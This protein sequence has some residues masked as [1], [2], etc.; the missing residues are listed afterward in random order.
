MAETNVDDVLK[1]IAVK[2]QAAKERKEEREESGVVN[3]LVIEMN[4]SGLFSVR[5]SLAG[6]VP[7]DLKGM[8]TRKDKILDIAKRKNVP[9]EGH[10]G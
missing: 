7:H 10:D 1:K 5:Y 9:V 8:F 3:K 4:P 6:P 2:K